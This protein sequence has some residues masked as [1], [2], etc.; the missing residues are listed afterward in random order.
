MVEQLDDLLAAGRRE[1]SDDVEAVSGILGAAGVWDRAT[2]R[3][4]LFARQLV[5]RKVT[6]S[7]VLT[8]ALHGLSTGHSAGWLVRALEA[9]P[10]TIWKA[11]S[12]GAREKVA[13]EVNWIRKGQA[14]ALVSNL[15]EAMA[16]RFGGA[17]DM[18][19]SQHGQ[20]QGSTTLRRL[21]DPAAV[22]GAGVPHR[23]AAT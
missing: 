23:R 3:R 18:V 21:T 12:K 19:P 13:G 8:W 7:D 22:P 17:V 4:R 2:T 1:W 11:R 20:A 16:V 14:D 10:E 5:R 6:P 15:I 9:D